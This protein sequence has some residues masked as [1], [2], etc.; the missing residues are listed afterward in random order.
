MNQRSARLF[1]LELAFALL[2]FAICSAVCVKIFSSA[3][4]VSQKSR[5]TSAAV[6]CAQ[7][8]AEA[9]KAHPDDHAAIM[10]VLCSKSPN[11]YLV[12]YYDQAWK[13][14]QHPTK[15][16]LT[17]SFSTEGTL[18]TA[19]ITVLLDNSV[20]FELSVSRAMEETVP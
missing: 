3:H 10:S 6:V 11:V 14:V 20:L 2:S 8:A 15:R 18:K 12:V 4:L 17:M 19:H 9:F 5:D 1:F 7:S 16:M 13:P